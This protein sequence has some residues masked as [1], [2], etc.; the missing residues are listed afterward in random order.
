MKRIG[1]IVLVLLLLSQISEAAI[2]RLGKTYEIAEK[3]ALTEIEEKAV[4]LD[5]S[6]M[7]E[8]ARRNITNYVPPNLPGE[9]PD[10]DK[11][12]VIEVDMTYTLDFDITD[13]K[14]NILYPKGYSFNPL[15]YVK[16]PIT[17]IFLDGSK[18]T[19]IEWFETSSYLKDPSVKV[20]ITRGSY[21][22]LMK[23]L[24][25]PVFYATKLMTDRFQIKKLPSVVRQKG[26]IM[27][28]REV[29]LRKEKV[30]K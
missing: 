19:H 10:A 12:R 3:D 4:Q 21:Y 2:E 7:T 16:F 29:F 5:W 17:L 26:K 18:K 14:G 27:E 8:R 15:D 11:E 9:F 24:K 30:A 25:R 6:K 23:R 22:E 1:I 13:G 20:L 28:M